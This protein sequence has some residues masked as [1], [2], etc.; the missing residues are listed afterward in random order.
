MIEFVNELQLLAFDDVDYFY[1]DS[2]G[3]WCHY[4]NNGM[5]LTNKEFLERIV[6]AIKN[7]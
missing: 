4:E 2:L 6:G 1:D 3:M 7:K 5:V